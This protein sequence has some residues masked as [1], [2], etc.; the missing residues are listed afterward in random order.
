MDRSALCGGVLL[1]AVLG[2]LA[3]AHAAESVNGSLTLLQLLAE[4][5]QQSPELKSR[6]A[7][8]R[9][10]R[11]R[12]AQA[13]AFEDPMLMV[14]L[15]Q[16][17]LNLQHVPLMF[18]LRQPIPWPGKLQARAAVA[19][20]EARRAE[21]EAA[22]SAR[23][24]RLDA[25]RA[26]YSYRLAVRTETVL[27]EA[28]KLLGIIVA[29]VNARYR[30]GRADLAELLKAQESL[31]STENLLLAVWGPSPTD[32]WAVGT[33]GV[34]LRRTGTTWN[35]ID[36]GTELSLFALSGSAAS[37]SPQN[38]TLTRHL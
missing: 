14:E 36:S 6:Q 10:A 13:R 35:R 29:S 2:Q 18:T 23:S 25:T 28:Q 4:I 38:L 11:E 32:T 33:R 9:A 1:C 7:E 19:E 12:P 24:L 8:V 3:P 17:P 30:V 20:P 5:E 27:G 15:W 16:A 26:Y 34:V 21:A 22:S 37:A 31:S